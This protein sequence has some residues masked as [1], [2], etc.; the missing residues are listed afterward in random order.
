V[1]AIYMPNLIEAFTAIHACQRIGAIYTVLFSGF[2]PEAVASRLQAAG[3]S[4]VIVADGSYRRGKLVPLLATLREARAGSPTVQHVI[5]VDRT[6]T[7]G[8]VAARRAPLRRAGRA[9]RG[10]RLCAAGSMR[11]RS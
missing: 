3:A 1:V 8:C 2:G 10:H 4:T 7:F 9:T 11:P 5:V 6:G